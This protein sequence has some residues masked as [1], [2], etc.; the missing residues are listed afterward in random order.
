MEKRLDDQ[1]RE[2]KD[3]LRRAKGNPDRTGSLVGVMNTDEILRS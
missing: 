3:I 1:K 2:I